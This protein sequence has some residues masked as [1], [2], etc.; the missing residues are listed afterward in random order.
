MKARPAPLTEA[1]FYWGTHSDAMA[2]EKL[3][4]GIRKFAVDRA[5]WKKNDRRSTVIV[6]TISQI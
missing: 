6:I 5:N 4:D 3:A 2:T 1:E